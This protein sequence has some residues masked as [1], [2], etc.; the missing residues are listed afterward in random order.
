[1]NE[2]CERTD[3]GVA[4]YYS[5]YSWLF[6]TI[7]LGTNFSLHFLFSDKITVLNILP[8][9]TPCMLRS[10]TLPRPP[11]PTVT[12]IIATITTTP[13]ILYLVPMIV[14]PISIRRRTDHPPP[15]QV[16]EEEDQGGHSLLLRPQW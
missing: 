5:M 16:E 1:M 6:S 3:E 13:A 9:R 15:I 11:P 14:V 8:L 10:G 12:T 2:R 4:Q 7:V